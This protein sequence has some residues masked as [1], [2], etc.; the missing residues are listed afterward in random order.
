MQLVAL[1]MLVASWV[2]QLALA[3]VFLIAMWGIA[4]AFRRPAVVALATGWSAYVLYM[5]ASLRFAV[6]ARSNAISSVTLLLGTLEALG[7]I[8]MFVFWQPTARALADTRSSAMPSRRGLVISGVFAVLIVVVNLVAKRELL[9][10]DSGPL[11][12]FYPV[13][14][15][16]L[17]VAAWR[18]RRRA[19]INRQT[20]L[21][22]GFGYLTFALRLEL[23]RDVVLRHVTY[24]HASSAR[25]LVV[26]LIQMVQVVSFGAICLIVALSI[27]RSAILQQSERLRHVEV[28]L[29]KGRR[30]ESLGEM[31]AR[32]AHDFNNILAV[33]SVGVQLARRPDSTPAFV[34][35]E[36]ISVS[37]A[38]QRAGELV[39]QLLAF[40]NPRAY[41]AQE[42]PALHVNAYFDRSADMLRRLMTDGVTLDIA[43]AEFDAWVAMDALQFEQIMMNLVVNARDAMPAGGAIRVEMSTV[44]FTSPRVLYED[45]MPAGSYLRTSVHD[46]GGGI[47]SDVLPRIFD[48]FFTTK[49]DEGTGLG[50]ATVYAIV[51]RAYGDV[52][53]RSQVG[54]GTRFDVYLPLASKPAGTAG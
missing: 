6:A 4:Y 51:H 2:M 31:A 50:L 43:A 26:A 52:A 41:S 32:V 30:L 18:M 12:Y 8:A 38:T 19:D 37:H 47:A 48:P 24:A 11:E 54:H 3:I 28:R 39:R 13:A 1:D 17:A 27:E 15:T 29:E 42:A 49:G 10:L 14:F 35:S 21:W 45:E 23:N 44:E 25:L 9:V 7:V 36:L 46:S 33:I 5:L 16:W 40:A 20:L 53:V 34:E 22:L